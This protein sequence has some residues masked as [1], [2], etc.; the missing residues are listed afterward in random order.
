MKSDYPCYHAP[1][2][3]SADACCKCSYD[4]AYWLEH[5]LKKKEE[6]KNDGM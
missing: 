4:M 5:M 2:M 1:C 6:N 3:W